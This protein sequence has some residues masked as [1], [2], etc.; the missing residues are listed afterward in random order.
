MIIPR[1]RGRTVVALFLAGL[2][3]VAGCRDGSAK[4]EPA[5]AGQDRIKEL[6]GKV[7]D[8]YG[9]PQVVESLASLSVE[10][11]VEAPEL[12]RGG[13]KYVGYAK[14]SGRLR[15]ETQSRGFLELRVLN[16]HRSYYKANGFP[17]IEVQGPVTLPWFISIK[18]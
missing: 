11:T 16:K 5:G 8:A 12:Y 15:V 1:L 4:K 17:L 13:A 9:G 10:G 3:A 6:V 14:R 18:S 2:L 7:V